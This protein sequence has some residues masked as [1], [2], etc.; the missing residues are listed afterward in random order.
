MCC[1]VLLRPRVIFLDFK[2]KMWRDIAGVKRPAVT[3]QQ[4]EDG[5]DDLKK[6]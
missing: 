4:K 3:G 1:C 5:E 6:E 2:T